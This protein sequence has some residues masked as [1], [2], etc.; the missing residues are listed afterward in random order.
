MRLDYV[1]LREVRES[2]PGLVTAYFH[3]CVEAPI[4]AKGRSGDT[5]LQAFH[6]D[7]YRVTGMSELYFTVDRPDRLIRPTPETIKCLRRQFAKRG[8]VV[9]QFRIFRR[10]IV[11][12]VDTV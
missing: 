6:P 2:K 4:A 12:A 3:G 7:F 1:K 5:D 9:T 11:L 10:G 8:H